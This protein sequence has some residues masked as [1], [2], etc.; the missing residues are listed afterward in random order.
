VANI[1]KNIKTGRIWPY[2]NCPDIA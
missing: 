1:S 2:K